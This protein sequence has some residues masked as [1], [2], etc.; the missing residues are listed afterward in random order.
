MRPIKRRNALVRDPFRLRTN[1]YRVLMTRGREG[2]VI[3]VPPQPK[4]TMDATA[5]AL[6][7]A[8]A[9]AVKGTSERQVA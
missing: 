1:A 2:L 3:W 4:A 5:A 7:R 6:E 9:V 8:G